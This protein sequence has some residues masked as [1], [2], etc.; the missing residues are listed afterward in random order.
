[1]KKILSICIILIN[2][3]LKGQEPV[4]TWS[5]HLKYDTAE[6]IAV[7]SREVF[8]STGSAIIVYNKEYNELK[9]LSKV[10]GLSET[11]ISSIAWSEE[12]QTLIIGYRSTNIDLVME[13]SIYNIPDI[14]NKSIP[15]VKRINRIRVS[16]RFAYIA[17]SFGIVVVDLVKR[18]IRDTWKP[19][20]DPEPNEVFDITFGN[21]AVYA[22]TERGIWSGRLSDQGLAY[23]GNWEPVTGLPDPSSRCTCI[24]FTGTKFYVNVSPVS[25]PGD[26]VYALDGTATLIS[27]AAGLLNRS[28]D[29]SPD[30]FLVASQGVLRHFNSD[31]SPGGSIVT[32][33]WG[34]PD[35]S[36]AVGENGTIWVADL[37]YGMI[38]V[39]KMTEFTRLT[40]PGPASDQAG[41]I[42]YSDGLTIICAGGTDNNWIAGGRDF[43]VSVLDNSNFIKIVPVKFHDAMR[44]CSE[45]G[46]PSHFYVSSWGDGLFEY[47][48]YTPV[49]NHTK[50]NTPQLADNSG[51]SG[52]RICGLATDKF[53]NLWITQSGTSGSIKVLKPDGSW[54]VNPLTIEAPVAADIISA[55]NSF[56]WVV[57]PGGYGLL[58]MDDNFT[59]EIFSDDRSRRL[60]VIDED[61][62]TIPQ[63]FSVAEDLDGNIWVGTSQGP[64]IYYNPARI[65]E[66]DARAGRIK[67]PRNDG[68]GLADYMLGTETITSIVADG[69][70]RKWLGTRNSGVYLLS[71]DGTEM[72]RNYNTHNSPLFS[73]SVSSVAVDSRTGEVWFGTSHGILSVREVATSGGENFTN[74]Y[75][76]PNP[77]RRDYTGNVTVK[78]LMRD[79]EIKI[80]NISGDLVYETHSEGGQAVWDLT[81]YSGRRVTTGVYLVFCSD[82]TGTKSFVTKILVIG[83]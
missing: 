4:G 39:E 60:S 56:K 76:F 54:I 31:G 48:N 73:D 63:V 79:S 25:S 75:A 77:V 29:T 12:N 69:A 28:F 24:L 10:T 17:A 55:Q 38:R 41:N 2:S 35:V 11:G 6:D 58:V 74:V 27:H 65:F 18:E 14:L 53:G 40:L 9:K 83:K 64:V 3:V 42:N 5:D 52:T 50:E 7:G 51:N 34:I 68:S 37:D 81:T 8:A 67:V 70:N 82:D 13:N 30:G 22:A 32:Y 45:T 20:P 46:N 23:F 33:G 26:F 43:Q 1:M 49:K 78:G 71:A 21:D 57:L 16:G 62:N 15:G 72:L 44:S 66:G 80:T 36:Q 47:S 19:G 59:P 61:G